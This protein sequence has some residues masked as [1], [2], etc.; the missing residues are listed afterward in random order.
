MVVLVAAP[1]PLPAMLILGPGL[2]GLTAPPVLILLDLAVVL[3]TSTSG[4]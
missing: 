3:E 4:L 1:L 2:R